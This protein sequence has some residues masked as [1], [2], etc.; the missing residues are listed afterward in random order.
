[1]TCF[2]RWH[3]LRLCKGRGGALDVTQKPRPSKTPSDPRAS[4]CVASINKPA[5]RRHAKTSPCGA[6]GAGLG[7]GVADPAEGCVDFAARWI[8]APTFKYS[9][10]GP[11]D[12]TRLLERVAKDHA[13]YGIPA[14][15]A[16]SRAAARRPPHRT[17]LPPRDST[18]RAAK[19]P[20]KSEP[21]GPGDAPGA[22][23]GRPGLCTSCWLS[24]SF[25]KPQGVTRAR[26][27]RVG[28]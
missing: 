13:A 25:P 20:R 2:R 24:A 19:T 28:C 7:D 21:S 14:R 1:L 27:G 10:H 11:P 22:F 9:N 6:S 5:L 23:A 8:W 12:G 4:F 26:A 15:T 16:S 3:A 18:R 17:T